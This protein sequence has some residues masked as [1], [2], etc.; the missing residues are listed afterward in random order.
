MT[1][2]DSV[3]ARWDGAAKQERP[4]EILVKSQDVPGLLANISQSFHNAGVN[5]T[6]VNCRTSAD[7]RAI[8]NLQFSFLMLSN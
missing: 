3:D 4:V 6:A 5:I 2:R 1:P 7:R 8:N